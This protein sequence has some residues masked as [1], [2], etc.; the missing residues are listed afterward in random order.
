MYTVNLAAPVSDAIAL[1]PFRIPDDGTQGGHLAQ[2]PV[3]QQCHQLRRENFGRYSAH[4]LCPPDDIFRV[5]KD[6]KLTAD[7]QRR[8]GSVIVQ[9]HH[10]RMNFGIFSLFL[11]PNGRE[12]CH[13]DAF[14]MPNVTCVDYLFGPRWRFIITSQAI[15]VTDDETLVY[16]DLTY[17]YGLWKT[18]ARP[19]IDWQ[20][21]TIIRQDIAI[22]GQQQNAASLW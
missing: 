14:H 15:P 16:T 5:R 1:R 13:T 3:P 9:Y 10:E 20:A 18:P 4:G 12:I 7:V 11:N 8:D 17:N 21:R 2:A 22:L 19:I 6:E